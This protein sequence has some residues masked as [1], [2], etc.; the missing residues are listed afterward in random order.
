MVTQDLAM[1]VLPR[2]AS[3][4]VIPRPLPKRVLIRNRLKL[5]RFNLEPSLEDCAFQVAARPAMTTMKELFKFDFRQCAFQKAL[6]NGGSHRSTSL[7][8]F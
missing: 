3:C 5:S 6:V 4:K 8:F 2:L 1:A 7:T